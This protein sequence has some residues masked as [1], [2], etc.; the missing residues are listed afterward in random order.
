MRFD[1]YRPPAPVPTQSW[2]QALPWVVRAAVWVTAL[3]SLVPLTLL[4][5][6]A[7]VLTLGVL[8]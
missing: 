6:L 2:W 7:F 4:L 1:N 3:L 5:G 8:V